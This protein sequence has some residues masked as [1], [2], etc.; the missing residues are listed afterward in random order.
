MLLYVRIKYKNRFQKH[1]LL[2]ESRA[3]TSSFPF[4]SCYI[5]RMTAMR[6]YN[7]LFIIGQYVRN[8]IVAKHDSNMLFK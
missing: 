2:F 1:F 6:L 4:F 3:V 7:T 5:A 8:T